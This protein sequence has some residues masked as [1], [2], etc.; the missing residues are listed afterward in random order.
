MDIRERLREIER[1]LYAIETVSRLRSAAISEGITEFVGEGELSIDDG[2]SFIINNGGAIR[3]GSWELGANDDGTTYANIGDVLMYTHEAEPVSEYI[4]LESVPTVLSS[5]I[6][7]VTA[8]IPDDASYAVVIG[9]INI[10][11]DEDIRSVV[12]VRSHDVDIS[13][14]ILEGQ[15][16]SIPLVMKFDDTIEFEIHA[17]KSFEVDSYF[18]AIYHWE[19]IT[20][21]AEERVTTEPSE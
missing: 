12:R 14:V 10:M 16:Q 9:S 8:P 21:A 5:P 11:A 3:G 7:R 17:T 6:T 4:T 1:R 13:M 2:G 20:D 15:S 19:V 18:E